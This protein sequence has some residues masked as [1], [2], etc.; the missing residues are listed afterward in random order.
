MAQTLL[1]GMAGRYRDGFSTTHIVKL[2]Q[3]LAKTLE[4]SYRSIEQI[5]EFVKTQGMNNP[6]RI[7]LL[8]RTEDLVESTEA[9]RTTQSGLGDLRRRLRSTNCGR[10]AP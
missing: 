7:A 6:R 1:I 8:L 3:S 4:H 5:V 9:G 10:E 2:V